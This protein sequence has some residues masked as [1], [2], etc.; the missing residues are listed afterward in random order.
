MVMPRV[1]RLISSFNDLLLKKISP[2]MAV[3]TGPA[4]GGLQQVRTVR[5][6]KLAAIQMPRF[7][8]T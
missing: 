3:G 7:N 6:A 4:D 8:S 2:E 1:A 5:T